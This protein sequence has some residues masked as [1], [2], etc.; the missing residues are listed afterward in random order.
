MNILVR[1]ELYIFWNN[2]SEVLEGE[3]DRIAKKNKK[4]KWDNVTAGLSMS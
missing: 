3:N 4:N 2:V 1:M